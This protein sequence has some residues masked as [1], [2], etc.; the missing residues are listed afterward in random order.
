MKRHTDGRFIVQLP[1][2]QDK[3]ANLGDS[4]DI[5]LRRYKALE[6]RLITQPDI[7]AEY[8][9]FMQ[10]YIELGH[11]REIN[12]YRELEQ[13]TQVYY[14]PHHVVQ[15][16]TSTTTKFRV[17]FDGFCKTST[18]LSLNDVLMVGPTLQD[19]LFSQDS[20]HG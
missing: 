1:I 15:N 16:E 20:S 4:H 9:R 18:G 2:K 13:N 11:M 17:V 3:L 14:L 12:N 19:D 6:A 10:E 8:K 5:T 7:Y